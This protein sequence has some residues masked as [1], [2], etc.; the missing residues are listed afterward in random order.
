MQVNQQQINN[1]KQQYP[2]LED[3]LSLRPVFWQNPKQTSMDNVPPMAVSLEDME[4]AELL[5]QRFAPFLAKEFEDAEPSDGIIESPLREITEMKKALNAHYHTN[6]QGNLY[7]KCD[8]EL[9]I[10][11]SIKA[12]GG[13]YEVLYLAEQLAI[14]AGLISKED[15]YEMFS[16][17]AFRQFFSNY[18]IG[19][20]ST[21]NLGLS[22]GI[23][24]ARLGFQT[25]VYMSSDAK[26]WKKDLLRQKGAIVYECEG[27][28]SKAITLGRER[29]Q[30]DPNAYFVDD[31][32]SKQLFLGYSVAA[33]R[34]KQQLEEKQVAVDADH[35]LFVYLPCGVGGAPGG[36]TFGLKQVFGDAVHCFFVEPTHS[37]AVLIG[38]LTGEKEKV[39]VQDFGID[40]RT[41]A[42]GLAVGRPSSFASSISEKLVSGVYTLEDG[43]LFKLLVMLSDSEGIS[44]EPSA[45]AGL[46]GPG[47]VLGSDYIANHGL[48][49]EM[50]THIVWATGGNLVPREDMERF[51][52]KGMEILNDQLKY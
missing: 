5:W 29:T 34:L 19:V 26:Q 3:V 39:S 14:K 52:A 50:I 9:P 28:F 23:I 38:L 10:A 41:E 32:K 24:G 7:L 18:S 16:K 27:D 47:E 31:E 42:D 43:E 44:V 4:Q 30:A 2:L 12:R 1:W 33:F 6:I 45:T 49:E 8:N 15:N 25:S 17:P 22:I 37:P 35:P 13:V 48:N 11:G 51:Y 40:N 21:G 36:I 46:K 20:G